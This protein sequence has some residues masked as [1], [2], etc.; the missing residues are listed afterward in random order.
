M[1]QGDTV[2]YK[3]KIKSRITDLSLAGPCIIIQFK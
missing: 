1:V 2:E 3:Q